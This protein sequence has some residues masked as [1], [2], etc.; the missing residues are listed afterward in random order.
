[1]YR[2]AVDTKD[3]AK[4]P[5]RALRARIRRWWTAT[6]IVLVVIVVGAG[7]LAVHM[8]RIDKMIEER[9]DRP[10]KWNLPSRVYADAEYIYPGT[11]IGAREI[12][13]KLDRLGYR[14]VGTVI[15]TPGDYARTANYL[16]IY[17][18]DFAY[19]FES[20][21]GFSVRLALSGSRIASI[22]NL[23][24]GEQLEFV[25]LEPEE[26]ASIFDVKMESRTFVTIDEVPKH[27]VAAIILI[28]DERFFKHKGV[29]P[30]G[31]LRATVVNVAHMR[32]AQGGS[33]LTQQLVKNF[34]LYPKKSILRK[35]NEALI[36]L[37]IERHHS[38]R[39]ILQAYLNEI[40]LGQRGSSSIAG[41]GEAARVYFAKDVGQLTLG[42]CAMLAGMI[43]S[44]NNF[45]PSKFPDR[46]AERRNLVLGRMAEEGFI[47]RAERDAAMAEAVITPKVSSV[48][49][50]A[51]YFIDFVK[52]QL[53]DLYPQEVLE[54]EGLRIFTTLDM[55]LE[56]RA[57]Q[58][59][60]DGLAGLEKDYAARLPK[61][62]A[63]LLQGALVAIQPS[64]GYVR[65]LVGGRSYGDSQYNR[66]TQAKRQPGSTFKPF[67][68][69]TAFD[70]RRTAK[71]FTPATI[72]DDA[73]FGVTAGGKV[74]SP[75]NYDK[76]SHGLVSARQ[77]LYNSYNIAT[78]KIALMAGLKNVATTARDAGITGDIPAV[79]SMALGAIEVSP[80][81]LAAAYTVF[82]NGGMKAQ[83]LSIINVVT[84][85]GDVLERK[86]LN[87]KRAF[88]PGPIYLTTSVMKDVLDRGTGS[89]ARSLGFN[90]IAAGKTG[91]TSNY[92]DAWFAG[93][94]PNLLAL[95]WVG[96][97]DNASMGL[98]GT[99]AA[100][101]L[102]T[103]FMKHAAPDSTQDFPSPS[104]IILVKIN[105]PTGLLVN[106]QCP[107][108][109][110]EPFIE[111]TEPEISCD[112]FVPPINEKIEF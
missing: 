82:P 100:L 71:L 26:I 31:I 91:T 18:H 76:K 56:R 75:N 38:K 59:V 45:S 4:T 40:Y 42:E 65:A 32:I 78:A 41:V 27:L 16:D 110:Y 74:W 67:V 48:T 80:L 62:A 57:E 49:V 22:T 70:P 29:D 36:A 112:E 6:K 61:D 97:D 94:T 105:P 23:A 81:E 35:L 109:V 10:R 3:R 2:K 88:D 54:S 12:V 20:F 47:T 50:Q 102:W 103:Q 1:M 15:K 85:D 73:P 52:M 53:A 58:A 39:E 19:P 63:G 101:P 25:K 99:S 34:F 66:A 86:R 84:K 9:F 51:P 8:H 95:V 11:D 106:R 17:L 68:Y 107:A 46:A 37:R 5:K 24:S 33:T 69:L 55:T 96:Y 64:N 108:F 13:A 72:V 79:P 111:G 89:R 21:T 44:P 93:F 104:N 92:R 87:I 77:A 98:S 60:A 90:G 14:D 83:P 30:I 28:E 7:L 43:R